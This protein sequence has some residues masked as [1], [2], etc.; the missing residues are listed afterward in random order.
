MGYIIFGI[1]MILFDQIT[2]YYARIKLQTVGTI[3][4]IEDFFHLTYVE[5]RGAAF[6]MLQ[7]QKVLFT[8]LTVCIVAGL[9]YYI[10][11]NRESRFLKLTGTFIVVGA[12]GNLIDRLVLG[13]VV[14][15]IDFRGIWQYVFNVADIFVVC[16]TMLLIL[17]ILYQDRKERIEAKEY[18]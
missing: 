8:L 9:L 2:K 7:G 13:Y 11:Q 18:E 1:M 3:P 4:V 10:S 12:I 16:G 15:F 14:D 5:N 17:G 6:G